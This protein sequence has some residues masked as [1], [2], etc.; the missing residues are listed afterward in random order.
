MEKTQI[1]SKISTERQFD[2]WAKTYDVGIWNQYFKRST[3]FVKNYI[4]NVALSKGTLLDIG[5]GTGDLC[6]KM[7]YSKSFDK[8]IGVDVSTEMLKQA[9]IKKS[10]LG[11][12]KVTFVKSLA[13]ELP[14]ESNSVDV[15]TCLNSFHHHNQKKTIGEVKRVLKKSGLFLVL[16]PVI[17]G[18]VRITW[19]YM[20]KKIFKEPDVK[21]FSK[22]DLFNLARDNGLSLQNQIPFMYFTCLTVMKKND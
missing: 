7:C 3:N 12:N 22:K 8:I 14:L 1:K 11:L 9:N 17:D 4:D 16:D 19:A 2:I 21:Y 18:P 5:C 13:E 20:L 6:L 15:I 10:N